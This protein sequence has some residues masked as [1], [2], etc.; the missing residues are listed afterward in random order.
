LLK[1]V[2]ALVALVAVAGTAVSVREPPSAL[3]SGDFETRDL[4]QWRERQ[5]IRE[6]ISIGSRRPDAIE[7]RYR[8]KFEVQDGDVEPQTGSERC[9]LVGPSLPDERERWFR[10]AMYVPSAADPPDGWEIMSQ[11]YS[12]YGGSP[13]LALFN[14]YD[15]PMRWSLR[16]GDSSETY[17]RSEE[18]ARDRWHEIVVGVF[19]SQSPSRGWV[20]VWLDGEQQTLENG[21]TRMYG[22]TRGSAPG[23]FKTGIYRSPDSTGTSIQYLDDFSV[24]SSRE[25][26]SS[27]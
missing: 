10:L 4:S 2:A 14:D 12:I 17:W 22:Q 20:E 3:H 6:R 1:L 13:P 5:C 18:L 24:G 15:L 11:W 26:V 19:L 23:A 21:E 7:G 27:D 8:A 9:E 25:S 16:R